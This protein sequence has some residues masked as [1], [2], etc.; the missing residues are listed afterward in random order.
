MRV[1]DPARTWCLAAREPE[2]TDGYITKKDHQGRWERALLTEQEL[3]RPSESREDPTLDNRK[4]EVLPQS[5][6]EAGCG[7]I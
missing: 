5:R 3:K 2:I 4:E 6:L 1:S 7:R